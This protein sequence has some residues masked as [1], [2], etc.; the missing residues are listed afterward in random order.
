MSTDCDTVWVFD[1]LVL[2]LLVRCLILSLGVAWRLRV[3][4]VSCFAVALVASFCR[5]GQRVLSRG[6]SKYV[7]TSVQ[8][9]LFL[10]FPSVSGA[11]LVSSVFRLFRLRISFQSPSIVHVVFHPSR[12]SIATKSCSFLRTAVL[13]PDIT[14]D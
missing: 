13:C 2:V 14:A 8:Y 10:V 9:F 6:V 4:L 11:R 7:F 5:W 1:C 12:I 3:S